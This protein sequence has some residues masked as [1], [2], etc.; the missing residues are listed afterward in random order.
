M[1][2]AR[3]SGIVV[4]QADVPTI[5]GMIQRG[6]RKH[7]IAAWL[8]LNQGRI[9]DAEEGKY[10]W[11]SPAPASQLPPAGSPGPRARVLRSEVQK[12]LQLLNQQKIQTAIDQLEKAIA[13]FDKDID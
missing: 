7:D 2:K 5:L 8:G 4:H 12:V 1:T 9:A 13:E 3:R 6:D 11:H 10:G